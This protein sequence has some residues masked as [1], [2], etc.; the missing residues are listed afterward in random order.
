MVEGTGQL[1]GDLSRKGPLHDLIPNP[2]VQCP[3]AIYPVGNL[4]S[5]TDIQTVEWDG[6]D[7]GKTDMVERVN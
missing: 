1:S 7:V 4:V 6:V 3:N 5:D 2:T